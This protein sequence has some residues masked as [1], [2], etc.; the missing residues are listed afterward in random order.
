MGPTQRVLLILSRTPDI[1][2]TGGATLDGPDSIYE[3][4]KA[5]LRPKMAKDPT[6]NG[7]KECGNN[8]SLQ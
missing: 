5:L 6:P 4:Q 7:I 8:Y 2:V 1:P 3:G